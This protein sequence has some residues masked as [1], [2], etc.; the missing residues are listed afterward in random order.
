MSDTLAP[1]LGEATVQEL[2]ES[3][4]G[5]VLTPDDEG[6]AQASVIWNGTHDER[7]PALILRCTGAADVIAAVGFA[8][9]NGI[10]IAVRGGGH[11]VAGFSAPGDGVGS[12]LSPVGGRRGA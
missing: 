12:A 9:G 4:R 10:P 7:R 6:Y 8:R 1:V 3:V 2:R 11:N 5:A